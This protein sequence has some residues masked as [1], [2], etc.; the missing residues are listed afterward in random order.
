MIKIFTTVCL[1][2]CILSQIETSLGMQKSDDRSAKGTSRSAKN[3]IASTSVPY[4][5]STFANDLY[6]MGN[7]WRKDT[8]V[9]DAK[10]LKLS[11][12]A[13]SN[14]PVNDFF[15][16]KRTG[17]ANVVG[18]VNMFG[19]L[20]SNKERLLRQVLYFKP[21]NNFGSEDEINSGLIKKEMQIA[22][23]GVAYA[24]G[25]LSKYSRKEVDTCVNDAFKKISEECIDSGKVDTCLV[26]SL[27]CGFYYGVNPDAAKSRPLNAVA[28]KRYYKT[29]DGKVYYMENEKTIFLDA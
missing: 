11:K 21:E 20:E 16:I 15:T 19:M 1:A 18:V 29:E 9:F 14:E 7:S 17:T 12:V 3:E 22:H 24:Y 2:I 23:L 10:F 25:N 28:Q 6:F 27:V 8:T 13:A 4:D 26:S 5:M